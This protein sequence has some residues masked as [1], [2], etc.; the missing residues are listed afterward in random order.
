MY[1]SEFSGT[2]AM[3][4]FIWEMLSFNA[5]ILEFISFS[6][7]PFLFKILLYSILA[8]SNCFLALFNSFLYVC[9]LFLVDSNCFFDVYIFLYMVY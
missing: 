5:S 4:I 6:F 8:E 1:C 9:K 2:L 3:S 7:I